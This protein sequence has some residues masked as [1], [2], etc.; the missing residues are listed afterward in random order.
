MHDH[1]DRPIRTA[2]KY[3]S[4]KVNKEISDLFD[5]FVTHPDNARNEIDLLRTMYQMTK[6]Y[7]EF[8]YSPFYK[9]YQQLRDSSPQVSY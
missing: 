5:E 2:R 8:I 1:L 9:L 3:L 7:P 4:K 6:K